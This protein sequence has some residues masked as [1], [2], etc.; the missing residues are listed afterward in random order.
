MWLIIRCW[1]STHLL[2]TASDLPSNTSS[3][4]FSFIKLMRYSWDEITLPGALPLNRFWLL[5]D[6]HANSQACVLVMDGCHG[7]LVVGGGYR[8]LVECRDEVGEVKISRAVRGI[9]L[10]L[11]GWG[12]LHCRGLEPGAGDGS[13]GLVA[14]VAGGGFDSLVAGWVEGSLQVLGLWEGR[15]NS[16]ADGLGGVV[17][18][19]SCHPLSDRITSLRGLSGSPLRSFVLSGRSIR[20]DSRSSGFVGSGCTQHRGSQGGVVY[21]G[22]SDRGE[23]VVFVPTVARGVGRGFDGIVPQCRSGVTYEGRLTRPLVR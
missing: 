6:H 2:G 10:H 7:R 18:G 17:H 23:L 5:S 11:V 14:P 19:I 9:G 16:G 4:L 13:G 12:C 15:W 21:S 3:M 20:R 22:R 1:F 8:L